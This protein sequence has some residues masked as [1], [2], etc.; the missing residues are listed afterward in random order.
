ME[1]MHGDGEVVH[2]EQPSTLTE[3]ERLMIQGSWS[4]VYQNCDDA[5]V[6]ILVRLFVNFPS[7]KQFFSQFKNIEEPE[8]LESSSQLRKHAHRV[9]TAINSLVES[10]DNA[11][12]M[13]SVLKLVGTAHAVRHKVEPH[14]FKI[15]CDVILEVLGESFPDAVTP[16]VAAAW[17]KLM[18]TVYFGIT[19]IYEEV[20]W[21]KRSTS[22]G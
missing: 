16:E 15:L 8:E 18:D 11:D 12:K 3:K 9:M 14:Y 5:G 7:S 2:L 19:A 10:L 20:G 1:R 21:E 17:S 22:T 4:K 6:A 13:G